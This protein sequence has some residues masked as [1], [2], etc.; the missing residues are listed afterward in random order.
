MTGSATTG[1][2]AGLARLAWAAALRRSWCPVWSAAVRSVRSIDEGGVESHTEHHR[3]QVRSVELLGV[4]D[5]TGQAAE[6]LRHEVPEHAGPRVQRDP[7]QAGRVARRGLVEEV[8]QELPDF[9]GRW[10]LRVVGV[11]GA[12]LD[13]GSE[14]MERQRDEPARGW[15]S[16]VC[17]CLVAGHGGAEDQREVRCVLQ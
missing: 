11:G 17:G 5:Q 1:R 2:P 7:G 4:A 14:D 10:Y 16:D 13:R 15:S 6:D 9:E 8:S 12:G 3:A